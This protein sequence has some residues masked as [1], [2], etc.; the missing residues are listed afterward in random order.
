MSKLQPLTDVVNKK[1]IQFCIF[2]HYLSIDEQMVPYFGRHSCKMFKSS[3]SIRFG[4]KNLV[5]CG[6]DG[7]PY[8][9]HP[10]QACENNPQG[11]LLETRVVNSFCNVIE[12]AENHK[13]Y[14]DNLFTPIPLLEDMR[15]RQIKI[16]GTLPSNRVQ[17]CPITKRE[18]IKKKERG[19]FEGHNCN[20]SIVR[21]SDN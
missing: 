7:C 1:L 21:W 11:G 19:F 17:N 12:N 6:H 3:K 8:Q 5:L 16:T 13:V 9:V 15:R 14:F 20:M 10:Y 2:S 4:Y 18:T